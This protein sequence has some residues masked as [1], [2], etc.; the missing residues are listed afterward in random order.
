MSTV[1]LSIQEPD[2]SAERLK[3]Q[4][5]ATGYAIVVAG[6]PDVTWRHLKVTSPVVDGEFITQSAKDAG[7][8]SHRIR[9][10]GSTRVQ[11][12]QRFKALTD[13]LNATHS[14]LAVYTV[15]GVSTAWRAYRADIVSTLDS[16]ALLMCTRDVA[17]SIPVLPNP[18]VTGI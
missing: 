8:L 4:D 18:T 2:G 11:V 1:S 17:V 9:V 12:E 3:V 16:D 5:Q 10:Y 13:A 14:W 7:R 15:D 6:E